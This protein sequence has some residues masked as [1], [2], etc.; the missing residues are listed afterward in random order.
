MPAGFRFCAKFP[1]DISHEGDLRERLEAAGD[2]LE[3]LAPLGER[4]SP[5]WLQL[6][7]AFT[8]QRLGELLYFLDEL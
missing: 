5:L 2:F 3:L 4:V 6:S 7:A 1:R 8:P